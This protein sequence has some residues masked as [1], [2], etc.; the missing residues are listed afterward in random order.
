MEERYPNNSKFQDRPRAIDNPVDD[1]HAV[2]GNKKVIKG[3]AQKG[4][5]T[6]SQKF[7]ETFTPGD[8]HEVTDHLVRDIFIPN[9]IDVMSDMLHS[10]IDGMIFGEDAPRTPYRGSRK[11]NKGS[12]IPFSSIS[13][14]NSQR[15][16]QTAHGRRTFDFDQILLDSRGEAQLVLDEMNERIDAYDK[17]TVADLYDAV[18][19][20]HDYT[21]RKY[22]WYDIS[23]AKITRVH[24]SDG[25]KFG[26]ILPRP[27]VVE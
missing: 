22:G 8:I 14:G 20:D 10:F 5:K 3:T 25:Y 19:W 13:T 2:S 16:A 18:G 24:T 23:S 7:S 12:N 1:V 27:E 17:C 15:R 4:K 6:L 11:R 9:V 21:E 26:L